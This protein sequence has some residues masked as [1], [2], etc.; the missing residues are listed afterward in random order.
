[1]LYKL[2]LIMIKPYNYTGMFKT[3]RL[4]IGSVNRE[5]YAKQC[6]TVEL[7][8]HCFQRLGFW[9]RHSISY[10]LDLQI[11]CLNLYKYTGD[12]YQLNFHSH[13]LNSDQIIAIIANI[14]ITLS[15]SRITAHRYLIYIIILL[16]V[17]L[18]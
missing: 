2:I 1:M 5:L 12:A 7:P 8:S 16:T 10:Y 14:V 3:D 17:L 13:K 11:F 6:T 9:F 4:L 15:H 18:Q